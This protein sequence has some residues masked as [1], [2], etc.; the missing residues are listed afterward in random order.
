VLPQHVKERPGSARTTSSLPLAYHSRTGRSLCV[1]RPLWAPHLSA[2]PR[3]SVS[4]GECRA[5]GAPYDGCRL[6][7]WNEGRSGC[8]VKGRLDE[9]Q[10]PRTFFFFAITAL[11]SGPSRDRPLSGPFAPYRP[12]GGLLRAPSG[13]GPDRAPSPGPLPSLFSHPPPLGGVARSPENNGLV[14]DD[15]RREAENGWFSRWMLCTFPSVLIR[16]ALRNYTGSPYG[17]S[18]RR[19]LTLSRTLPPGLPQNRGLIGPRARRRRLCVDR[20]WAEPHQ[21]GVR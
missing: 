18:A 5:C 15:R 17:R 7:S 4:C 1:L 10:E 12:A 9:Y 2:D 14:I 16:N 19:S 8:P 3:F 13:A 20:Q 6:V 21:R 11:W